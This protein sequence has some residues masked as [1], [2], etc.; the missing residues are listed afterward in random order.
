MAVNY[1]AYLSSPPLTSLL[2]F[3]GNLPRRGAGVLWT[4]SLL[5]RH[6]DGWWLLDFLN[7]NI[8]RLFFFFFCTSR[9]KT[10]SDPL[11][12]TSLAHMSESWLGSAGSRWLSLAFWPPRP[13]CSAVAAARPRCWAV[14]HGQGGSCLG[15]GLAC[16]LGVSFM[17]GDW[18]EWSRTWKK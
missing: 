15:E 3:P 4:P 17:R 10:E 13:A 2:C 12:L 18:N 8:C 11:F 7:R 5:M 14:N 6:L 1:L 9:G 16:Q